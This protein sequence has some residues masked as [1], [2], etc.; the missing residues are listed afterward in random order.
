MKQK[1]IAV[2]LGFSLSNAVN[3][4]EVTL[5]AD[6]Y[7][8]VIFGSRLVDVAKKLKEQVNVNNKECDYV[9]FRSYPNAQFMVEKGIITRVNVDPGIQNILLALPV[10]TKRKSIAVAIEPHKYAA[11]GS[12]LIFKNA[13]GKKAVVMEA[14]E[15][16]IKNI[17]AGLEPSVEYVEGCS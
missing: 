3:A 4:S 14:D 17:R 6:T 15:G 10:D 9:T 5:S 7:G 13:D 11:A 8:K 16:K 2:V 12:Y 1:L